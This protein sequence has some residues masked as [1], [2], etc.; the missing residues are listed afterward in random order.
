MDEEID[1]QNNNSLLNVKRW[2][3]IEK[4]YQN[5]TIIK[6]EATDCNILHNRSK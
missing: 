6:K 4:L 5:L 3:K 1:Y 2:I